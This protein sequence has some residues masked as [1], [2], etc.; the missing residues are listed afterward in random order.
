MTMALMLV[1]ASVVGAVTEEAGFRG[2][3]QGRLERTINGPAAILIAS[4]VMAP[5]QR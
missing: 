2:Y 3:F 5:A 4:V 1:M